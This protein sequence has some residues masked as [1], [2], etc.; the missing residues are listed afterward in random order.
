MKID[1]DENA[2]RTLVNEQVQQITQ[3]ANND[4]EAL[5]ARCSRRPLEEIKPELKAV[6]EK[7]GGQLSEPELTDYAQ[8]IHDG[9]KIV[10]EVDPNGL[11]GI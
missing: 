8:R 5:Y 7:R 11:K 4:M 6:F 1:F 2:L 3:D 10:F 9:V